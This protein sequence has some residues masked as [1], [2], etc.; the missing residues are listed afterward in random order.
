[1]PRKFN[2]FLDLLATHS[3]YSVEE[4]GEYEEEVPP[5]EE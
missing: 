5:E 2:F 1:M 4:E 3:L